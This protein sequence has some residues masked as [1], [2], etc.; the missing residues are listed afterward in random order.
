MDWN[1]AKSTCEALGSDLAVLNSEAK[2]RDFLASAAA[3]YKADNLWIGL[4]RDPTHKL[5]W[6]WVGGL[7]VTFAAWDI[8]QPGNQQGVED[9]GVLR[10]SS[11]KWHDDLCMVRLGYICEISGKYN[12]HDKKAV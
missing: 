4:H 8:S 11:E 2:L 3:A 12:L 10:I 6:L 7:Q 9:C 5:S 1:S